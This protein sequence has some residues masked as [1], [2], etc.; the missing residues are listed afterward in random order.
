M[1]LANKH[2][3]SAFT[4]M[5]VVACTALCASLTFASSS[6]IGPICGCLELV[7]GALMVV[8]LLWDRRRKR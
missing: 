6:R 1:A 3:D 4:L 2:K 5:V 8:G 7:G